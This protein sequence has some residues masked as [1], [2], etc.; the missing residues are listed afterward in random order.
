[1]H[2]FFFLSPTTYQVLYLSKQIFKKKLVKEE[3][4]IKQPFGYQI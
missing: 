1:M 4:P 3:D 2:F